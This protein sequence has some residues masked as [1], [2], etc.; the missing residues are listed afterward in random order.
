MS[1]SR[2]RFLSAFPIATAASLPATRR[3]LAATQTEPARLRGPNDQVQFA[4]IGAG[5]RGQQDASSALQV[6]NV[7]GVA[8]AD[9]YDGRLRH[10]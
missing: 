10:A 3:L 6:P 8:V 9:C 4:L 1:F 7:K 2:R 5:I